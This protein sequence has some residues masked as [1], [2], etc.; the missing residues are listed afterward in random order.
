[1]PL[2][3]TN[4]LR[5]GGPLCLPAR[6][7]TVLLFVD[8]NAALAGWMHRGCADLAGCYETSDYWMVRLGWF[9]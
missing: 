7:D 8:V 6:I 4:P 5:R 2:I 3:Q 1:M 9:V